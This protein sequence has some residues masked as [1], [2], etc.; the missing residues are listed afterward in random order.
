MQGEQTAGAKKQRRTTVSQKNET[1]TGGN[2]RG[3]W[4]REGQTKL[5]PSAWS[6][7]TVRVWGADRIVCESYAGGCSS[8]SGS[9]PGAHFHGPAR[10]TLHVHAADV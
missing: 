5:A 9:R 3:S 6:S 10:A 7:L 2:K 4:N 1:A 8:C